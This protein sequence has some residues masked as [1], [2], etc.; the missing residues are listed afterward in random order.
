MPSGLLTLNGVL[1]ANANAKLLYCY[2]WTS[3]IA[4]LECEM[5]GKW[6]GTVNIHNY[7]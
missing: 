4:G 5:N 6:N 2:L 7:S 3:L 1:M